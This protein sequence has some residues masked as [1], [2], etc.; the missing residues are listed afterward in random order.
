[1]LCHHEGK[2]TVSFELIA[3]VTQ[4]CILPAP[5]FLFM[6]DNVIKKVIKHRKRGLKW[7]MRESLEDLDFADD[8]CLLAQR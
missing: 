8:I 6:L 3:E 5:L 4:G 7:R 1:M 2:L